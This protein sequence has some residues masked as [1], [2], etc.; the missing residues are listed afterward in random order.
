MYRYLRHIV[1]TVYVI[2][3]YLLTVEKIRKVKEQR[4]EHY[5]LIIL[6][7]IGFVDSHASVVQYMLCIQKLNSQLKKNLISG[8]WFFFFLDVDVLLLAIFFFVIFGLRDITVQHNR[9]QFSLSNDITFQSSPGLT[10]STS[11]LILSSH[12]NLGRPSGLL[13]C[14]AFSSTQQRSLLT[15]CVSCPRESYHGDVFHNTRG[16]G[17]IDIILLVLY[18][19][20]LSIL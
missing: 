2:H 10:L 16:V 3:N 7:T 17:S 8:F 13:P 20:E 9:L 1:C 6:R 5:G 11:S 4:L 15:P 14:G 12:R 19:F 18:F